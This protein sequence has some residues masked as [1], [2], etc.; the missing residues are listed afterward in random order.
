L[1]SSRATCIQMGGNT[2]LRCQ[3]PSIALKSH[4]EQA[5]T[6]EVGSNAPVVMAVAV[7]SG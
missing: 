5:D 7:V 1:V 3:S 2:T 6:V 4:C